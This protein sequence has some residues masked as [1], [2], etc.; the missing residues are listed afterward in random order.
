VT[1]C[2]DALRDADGTASTTWASAAARLEVAGGALFGPKA[3]DGRDPFERAFGLSEDQLVG[4]RGIV[5][6]T[7]IQAYFA[8]HAHELRAI[9]DQRDAR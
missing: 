4:Q 9:G 7:R 6:S 1:G 2:I 3:D 5:E 8:R